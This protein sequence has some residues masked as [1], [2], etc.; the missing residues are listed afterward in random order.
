MGDQSANLNATILY[1][2]FLLQAI[3][4]TVPNP[5]CKGNMSF[6]TGDDD[7]DNDD[8]GGGGGGGVL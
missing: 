4:N 1:G 3:R 7:N 5:T 2:P 6:A 8:S